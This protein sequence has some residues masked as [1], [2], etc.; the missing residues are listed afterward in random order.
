MLERSGTVLGVALLGLGLPMLLQWWLRRRNIPWRESPY[1]TILVMGYVFAW[2]PAFNHALYG[3][4][5]LSPI[6]P[7]DSLIYAILGAIG[8]VILN[9]FASRRRDNDA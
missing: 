7:W 9:W 2:I 6:T 8:G 4:P 3:E 1:I 5:L